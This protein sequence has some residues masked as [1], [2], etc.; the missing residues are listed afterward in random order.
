MRCSRQVAARLAASSPQ[1]SGAAPVFL[2][3]E[4]V[5]LGTQT[6][7][8][9][10]GNIITGQSNSGRCETG[11]GRNNVR[12]IYGTPLI[13]DGRIYAGGFDGIL[14]AVSPN[15]L[16]PESESPC[17]P[18]FEADSAIVG[19]PTLTPDGAIL[20]GTEGG[21]LYSLDASN[22]AIRWTFRGRW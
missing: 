22:A 5:V 15:S 12:A 20:I 19:G 16:L 7:H 1:Q 8:I 4:T 13:Y 17:A 10:V 3:D 6:G 18:F 9:V 14:Y 21:T 2:D 11:E